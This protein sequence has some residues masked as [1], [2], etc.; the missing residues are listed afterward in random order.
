M[1]RNNSNKIEHWP[2]LRLTVSNLMSRSKIKK[3]WE[4]TFF[5]TLRL[6]DSNFTSSFGKLEW[7]YKIYWRTIAAVNSLEVSES[8][9]EVVRRLQ[10]AETLVHRRLVPDRE[11]ECF[12]A[13]TN[14]IVLLRK[15]VSIY[16]FGFSNYKQIRNFF[17]QFL[18]RYCIALMITELFGNFTSSRLAKKQ[19]MVNWLSY[20][21]RSE[22][23]EQCLN[24]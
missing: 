13:E 23:S 11:L 20:T 19:L 3:I 10:D 12:E 8:G 21:K 18:Y 15:S 7:Q 9:D 16:K 24:G 5:P 6:T 2:I 4:V 22:T 14:K 17:G 1:S